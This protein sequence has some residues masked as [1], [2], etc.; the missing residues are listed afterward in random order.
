MLHA[1]QSNLVR[2]CN[3]IYKEIGGYGPE[4]FYQKALLYELNLL[5]KNQ[6]NICEEEV[7]PQLYKGLEMS[8]K[9]LDIS[10]YSKDNGETPLIILEL[11]WID[12]PLEPWQLS[13]YMK[14]CNCKIGYMIN[15]EKLGS[16][17]TNYCAHFYDVDTNQQITFPTQ[18]PEYGRVIILRFENNQA[19]NIQTEQH[20]LGCGTVIPNNSDKPRCY[21]CFKAKR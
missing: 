21:T 17:P 13:N 2:L 12:I 6:Y 11:K 16:H 5:Y 1:F 8:S 15:F 20:C 3:E 10:I 9:R 19:P 7:I 18:V 14:L 4:K